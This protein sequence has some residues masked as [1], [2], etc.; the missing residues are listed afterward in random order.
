[1]L[2]LARK[3]G[4]TVVIGNDIVVTLLEVR[5]DK[6]RLGIEAPKN[7]VV[8]RGELIDKQRALFL[9]EL[10]CRAMDRTEGGSAE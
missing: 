8:L 7:M 3:P 9:N 2:C 5:G 1:M 4:E 6:I 10:G